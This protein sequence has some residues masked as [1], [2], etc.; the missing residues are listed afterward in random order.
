MT[1]SRSPLDGIGLVSIF[2]WSNN[3]A[4]NDTVNAPA[5]QFN[6]SRRD[7]VVAICFSSPET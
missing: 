4:K 7:N 3:R 5:L 2:C 6:Q 1:G